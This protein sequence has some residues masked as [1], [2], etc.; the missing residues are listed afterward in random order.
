MFRLFLKPPLVKYSITIM[1]PLHPPTSL[2]I[3]LTPSPPVSLVNA[4]SH[5]ATW[6]T[7]AEMMCKRFGY[8]KIIS[9]ISGTDAVDSACKIARKWGIVVRRINPE[10]VL[11]LGVGGCHHGLSTSMWSLQ[12][13]G[14]KRAGMVIF[15][16]S[17]IPLDYLFIYCLN[18]HCSTENTWSQTTLF[19]PNS[20]LLTHRIRIRHPGSAS[21]QLRSVYQG[22]VRIWGP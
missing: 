13:P 12:N 5:T 21:H 8:D 3:D 2:N 16:A 10:D 18:C 20:Q 14:P 22:I 17:L 7:F 19:F 15:R 9:M 11:I 6:P 4:A 1:G